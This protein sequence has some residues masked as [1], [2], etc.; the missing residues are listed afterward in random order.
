M[1]TNALAVHGITAMITLPVPTQMEVS[2]VRALMV[3]Q[4]ME[5]FVQV[6]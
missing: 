1:L 3:I 2:H 6:D 5:L 4:A